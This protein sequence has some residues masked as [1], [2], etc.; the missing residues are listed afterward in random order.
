[1]E[2]LVKEWADLEP[3]M[4][5]DWERKYRGVGIDWLE[6]RDAYQFGWIAGQ[7]P[8]FARYSWEEV[9]SDLAQH[10]YNPQLATEESAWDSVRE[11]VEEGWKKAR[12]GKGRRVA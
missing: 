5:K 1:M 10:W 3:V 9:E 8:E 7:R 11:A 4:R 2:D 6:I 12:A